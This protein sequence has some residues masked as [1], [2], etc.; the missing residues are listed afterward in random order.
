VAHLHDAWHWPDRDAEEAWGTMASNS[1][2][3]WTNDMDWH[4]SSEGNCEVEEIADL[5]LLLE[6][7]Q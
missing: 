2:Q 7:W 5:V 3:G 4:R 6:Y 1:L